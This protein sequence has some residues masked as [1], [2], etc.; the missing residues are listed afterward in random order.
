M[1]K[2]C[3]PPPTTTTSTTT[4]T[5]TTTTA[6]EKNHG[7]ITKLI[8]FFTKF[9]VS[10]SSQPRPLEHTKIHAFLSVTRSF[11]FTY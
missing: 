7:S 1:K 5:T 2:S 10:S 4:T 6:N 8:H 3:T 11:Y 9:T